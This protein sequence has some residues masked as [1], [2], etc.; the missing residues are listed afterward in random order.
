[1]S[2]DRRT[3]LKT[4]AASVLAPAA[5]RPL[6]M[7]QTSPEAKEQS[8]VEVQ[9]PNVLLMICDD[10]GF[11]DLG[12]YGSAVPTPN[13]DRLAAEGS[14]C[15]RYNSAHPICSAS[16]AALLT[17]RYAPRSHT[18]GA[19][20]PHATV[21]MAKEEQTLANLFKDAGYQT[22]AIGKWHLGDEPGYRPTER[23]FDT[24]FGVPYSDDMQ[25]L[26]LIRDTTTL[27]SDTNRD[28]LTPRYTEQVLRPH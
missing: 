6:G 17:G 2:N 19:L 5:L 24:Y 18:P 14:R 22:H 12:C 20:F 28:E 8:G 23:G 16:R 13:L 4:V 3:F 10:L 9:R 11:G 25:P 15:M 7:A 1:M 26:P 21:A 27:E